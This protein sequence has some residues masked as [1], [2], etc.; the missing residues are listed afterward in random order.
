MTDPELGDDVALTGEAGVWRAGG[1]VPTQ[2]RAGVCDGQDVPYA[3]NTTFT[4][5]DS[6]VE[7]GVWT[8]TRVTADHEVRAPRTGGCVSATIAWTARGVGG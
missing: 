2:H 7:E 4:V 6:Q 1:T 3:F 8:A 5:T